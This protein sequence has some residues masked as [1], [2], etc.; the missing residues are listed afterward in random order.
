MEVGRAFE[1]EL[2]LPKTNDSDPPK[3][4]ERYCSTFTLSDPVYVEDDA[5]ANETHC[6]RRNVHPGS[7]ND[8]EHRTLDRTR[9]Q[10]SNGATLVSHVVGLG[11]DLV[12]HR[13]SVFAQTGWG[14]PVGRRRS[15][16]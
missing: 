16:D 8:V 9:G 14:V 3:A 4:H 15:G 10:L 13:A 2:L 5:A 12:D 6:L 1:V 7:G 11:D